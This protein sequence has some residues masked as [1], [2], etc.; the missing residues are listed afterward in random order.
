MRKTLAE[1]FDWIMNESGVSVKI[2]NAPRR[3][4]GEWDMYWK[5][6]TIG[7]PGESDID[8]SEWPG[9][10][11]IDDCIDDLIYQIEN[12]RLNKEE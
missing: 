8:H 12:N 9:F 6:T 2:I 3:I 10:D 11:N 7:H 5:W 4:D 1:K